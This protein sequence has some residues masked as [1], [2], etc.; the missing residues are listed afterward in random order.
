[1]YRA[2]AKGSVIP[3]IMD[4]ADFDSIKKCAQT[5][6]SSESHLTYLILSGGV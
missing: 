5:F 4:L 3:I 2:G 6:K 1:M